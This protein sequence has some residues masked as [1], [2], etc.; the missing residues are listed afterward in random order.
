MLTNIADQIYIRGGIPYDGYAPSA[1]AKLAAMKE[2]TKSQS[3]GGK[4]GT[5]QSGKTG[6]DPLGLGISQ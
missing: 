2:Q 1:A 4:T 3:G 5:G 6:S